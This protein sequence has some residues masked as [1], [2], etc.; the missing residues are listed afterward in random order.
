ME[1]NLCGPKFRS[2]YSLCRKLG[3]GGMGTVYLA[4]DERLG[5]YLAVKFIRDSLNEPSLRARFIEEAKVLS[6]FHHRHIV[7]LFDYDDDEG[8][9]YLAFEFIEGCTLTAF[10]V[11]NGPPP[12]SQAKIWLQQICHAMQTAH[13]AG[14][15]HRDLKSDNILLDEKGDVHISDFGLAWRED[16]TADLTEDGSL[17]GTPAYMAPELLEGKKAAVSSDLYAA[18]VIAF[19][20]FAGRRPF[21]GKGI[22]EVLRAHIDSPVP[23]VRMFRKEFPP[24][25]DRI[26]A[27]LL[28]KEPKARYT[29]FQ[30]FQ[31]DIVKL[32]EQP[33][34]DKESKT[35]TTKLRSLATPAILPPAGNMFTKHGKWLLLLLLLLLPILFAFLLPEPQKSE[36]DKALLE[37]KVRR[38]KEGFSLAWTSKEKRRYGFLLLDSSGNKVKQVTEESSKIEHVLPLQGLSPKRDYLIQINDDDHSYEKKFKTP[39]VEFTRGVLACTWRRRVFIDFATNWWSN[40]TVT[41]K[42]GNA[43][44]V[45]RVNHAATLIIPK[46]GTIPSKGPYHWSIELDDLV[47]MS[48]TVRKDFPTGKQ[49]R[50]FE[51]PY[52]SVEDHRPIFFGEQLVTT[53]VDGV[54]TCLE[55]HRLCSYDDSGPRSGISLNWFFGP[56]PKAVLGLTRLGKDRLLITSH[57]MEPKIQG[58]PQLATG[59]AAVL[60]CI[61]PDERKAMWAKIKDASQTKIW[62]EPLS[63]HEWRLEVEEL[64]GCQFSTHGLVL[65]DVFYVQVQRK[66][67]QIGWCAF[68]VKEPKLLWLAW[69]K[70]RIQDVPLYWSHDK[71]WRLAAIH[72]FQNNS[73]TTEP[74][75]MGKRVYGVT[76]YTFPDKEYIALVSSFTFGKKKPTDTRIDFA[77][78]KGDDRGPRMCF[79][80]KSQQ[81]VMC[82]RNA[83]LFLKRGAKLPEVVETDKYGPPNSPLLFRFLTGPPVATDEGVWFFLLERRLTKTVIDSVYTDRYSMAIYNETDSWSRDI[84]FACEKEPGLFDIIHKGDF[85]LARAIERLICVDVKGKN[86]TDY[87]AKGGLQRSVDDLSGDFRLAAIAVNDEGTLA[88]VVAKFGVVE[89]IPLALLTA[90]KPKLSWPSR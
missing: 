56:R 48:G 31:D 18:G 45:E 37:A 58:K 34:T 38:G 83:L 21:Q 73:F 28:A 81:L 14:I 42:A 46:E 62:H 66:D 72:R 6:R 57:K 55:A 9:P 69:Q 12:I 84:R 47:L 27:R 71:K 15:I 40:L 24:S 39:S 82:T 20:V 32:P 49:A 1:I 53:N 70:R 33:I 76:N 74:I 13:N 85:I 8:H 80:E 64:R 67:L 63:S 60:W 4:L 75:V 65:N 52:E 26:L 10:I 17:V 79:D 87:G 86:A 29:S 23:S 54:I 2:R 22:I 16:R 5:R 11:D 78:N 88:A 7:Q 30:E 41:I 36:K 51:Q 77:F 59:E 44:Y 3:Q 90:G 61:C 25:G 35:I 43:K 68:S 19:E 89:I 50:L